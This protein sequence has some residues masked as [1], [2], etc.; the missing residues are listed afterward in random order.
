MPAEVE[1]VREAAA[2][3]LGYKREQQKREPRETTLVTPS[4]VHLSNSVRLSTHPAQL[5]QEP[6]GYATTV[7]IHSLLQRSSKATRKIR[8]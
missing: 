6:L 3:E 5:G 2:G 4:T 1:P 8:W 7:N